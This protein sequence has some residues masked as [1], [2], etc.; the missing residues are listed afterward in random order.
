MIILALSEG[1]LREDL[2][3]DSNRTL[4]TIGVQESGVRTRKT[5]RIVR[6]GPTEI[7]PELFYTTQLE[8]IWAVF[9]GS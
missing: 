7:N 8:R 1:G 6:P 3:S 4:Q 2:V 5:K 9:L